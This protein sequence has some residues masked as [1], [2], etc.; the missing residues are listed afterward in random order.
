MEDVLTSSHIL[1][2]DVEDMNNIYGAKIKE[3]TGSDTFYTRR[4]YKNPKEVKSNVK[5][6]IMI[7]NQN[8]DNYSN[9]I[10]AGLKR[11]LKIIHF[12]ITVIKKK[13]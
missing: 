5:K 8:L 13:Y 2:N 12:A 4:L 10:D 11:M 6:I 1:I 9:D 7:T 3:I